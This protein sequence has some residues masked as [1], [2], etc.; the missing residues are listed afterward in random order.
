MLVR[1]LVL[2]QLGVVVG[3]AV[4]HGDAA[5]QDGGHVVAHRLPLSLLLPLLLH[6]PQLDA[7]REEEEEILT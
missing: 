5:G 6:L 1:P 4:L 7:C 3:L 2:V